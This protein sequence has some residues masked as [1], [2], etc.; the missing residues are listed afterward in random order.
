MKV[1]P[2]CRGVPSGQAGALLAGPR[3]AKP[4]CPRTIQSIVLLPE[5]TRRWN[6]PAAGG[7][8]AAARGRARW[9]AGISPAAPRSCP[10]EAEP[11]RIHRRALSAA[12][13]PR[14]PRGDHAGLRRGHMGQ[15]PKGVSA[16]IRNRLCSVLFLP[17]CFVLFFFKALNVLRNDG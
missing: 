17:Q 16:S 9:A 5:L 7:A 13:T 2:D 4:R 12:R 1:R 3:L 14:R 11:L 15:R 6:V 8:R 10:T